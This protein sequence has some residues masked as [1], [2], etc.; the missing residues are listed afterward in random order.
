MK[1]L[2]VTHSCRYGFFLAAI[3]AGY[4]HQMSQCTI[5]SVASSRNMNKGRMDREGY[6]KQKSLQGDDYWTKHPA[7]QERVRKKSGYGDY[8]GG[9]SDT[10]QTNV[11]VEKHASLG[12]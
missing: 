8:Y 7:D 5:I 11:H 9:C 2:T 6:Q 1:T 3:T 10:Y 4:A 12:P